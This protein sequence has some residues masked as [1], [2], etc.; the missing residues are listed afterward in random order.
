M[1]SSALT[2]EGSTTVTDISSISTTHDTP[3]PSIVPPSSLTRSSPTS[4]PAPSSTSLLLVYPGH[5]SASYSTTAL[6]LVT[7]PRTASETSV[8]P[9]VSSTSI[10]SATF[11]PSSTSSSLVVTGVPIQALQTADL[12]RALG[13]GLGI[14]IS[15]F[16]VLV[17]LAVFFLIRLRRNRP[18][19]FKF[20]P[21]SQPD[22]RQS[23]PPPPSPMHAALI[24]AAAVASQARRP[25]DEQAS[26]A[27]APQHSQGTSRARHT[28]NGS[29]TSTLLTAPLRQ[30]KPSARSR[31]SDMDA[32]RYTSDPFA[33]DSGSLYAH[34]DAYSLEEIRTSPV[35][36]PPPA[37][38]ATRVE[39]P[40]HARKVAFA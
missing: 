21:L 20:E 11:I 13:A 35:T 25:S 3:R 32:P 19:A 39:Q 17:G 27:A 16:V 30:A 23:S 1:S 12:G 33:A 14:G 15:A 22:E 10:A 18:P 29:S 2:G 8:T 9:P 38:I 24:E 37:R 6:V 36:P 4:S 31:P 28:R 34:E 7:L 26:F 5:P 40:G